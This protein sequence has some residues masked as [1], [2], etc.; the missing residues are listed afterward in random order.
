[1]TN[2]DDM[3]MLKSFKQNELKHVPEVRRYKQSKVNQN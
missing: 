1:M 2:V 3:D